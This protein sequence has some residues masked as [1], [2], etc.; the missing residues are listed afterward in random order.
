MKITKQKITR[1]TTEDSQRAIEISDK[2]IE[3]GFLHKLPGDCLPIILFLITH[4]DHNN[5]VTTTTV[6]IAH[7]LPLNKKEVMEG[8][9]HLENNNIIDIEANNNSMIITIN[10]KELN[11]DKNK[12]TNSN[13][14]NSQKIA[15]NEN[16]DL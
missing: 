3:A 13:E 2:V 1:F 4:L 16:L 5:R 14:G 9:L 7:S 10:F 8:L 11:L 6:E 15:D 12:A